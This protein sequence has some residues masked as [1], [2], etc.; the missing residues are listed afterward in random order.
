MRYRTMEGNREH[1][2]RRPRWWVWLLIALGAVLIGLPCNTNLVPGAIKVGQLYLQS[3]EGYSAR[4]ERVEPAIPGL[5]VES[6]PSAYGALKIV[7]RTGEEVS[8]R[9]VS[10]TSVVR[11]QWE[12]VP[13]GGELLLACQV[14]YR[15]SH[16]RER[17][18]LWPGRVMKSW[19]VDGQVGK[20]RSS[21]MA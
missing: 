2:P 13:P 6:F 17:M 20:R 3:R 11:G 21:S 10:A 19:A 18:G 4:V 8:V 15:G 16:A 9:C 7:N 5:L 12:A 14:E 1:G